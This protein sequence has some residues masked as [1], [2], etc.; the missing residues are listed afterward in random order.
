MV[1]RKMIKK[2][3]IEGFLFLAYFSARKKENFFAHQSLYT[4]EINH[5]CNCTARTAALRQ[6][7]FPDESP[8]VST[9][10]LH[11]EAAETTK[12]MQDLW[13]SGGPI[14]TVWRSSEDTFDDSSSYESWGA[15]V[16]EVIS[17]GAASSSVASVTD[18]KAGGTSWPESRSSLSLDSLHKSDWS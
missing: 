7:G 5:T 16:A 4:Y 18:S 14:T 15:G 3:K 12:G 17:K 2:K 6:L 8:M 1:F 13:A 9:A 10:A 11:L